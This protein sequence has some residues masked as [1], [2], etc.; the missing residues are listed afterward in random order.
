[1]GETSGVI[2]TLLSPEGS[3]S[4]SDTSANSVRHSISQPA[5]GSVYGDANDT[6]DN[7]PDRLDA[8]ASFQSPKCAVN[9]TP[10]GR[11]VKWK[12]CSPCSILPPYYLTF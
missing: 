5:P 8:C 1:M 2:K 3:C 11:F 6:R 4:L 7:R 12:V 9:I 10:R